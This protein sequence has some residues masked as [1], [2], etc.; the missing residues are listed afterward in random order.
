MSSIISGYI[1][2]RSAAF[3]MSPTALNLY[4]IGAAVILIIIG[5]MLAA[6]WHPHRTERARRSYDAKRPHRADTDSC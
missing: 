5:L 6:L 1:G 2:T 3:I 4:L